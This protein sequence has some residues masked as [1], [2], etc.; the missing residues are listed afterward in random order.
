ML[1]S[2]VAAGKMQPRIIGT[3]RARQLISE[4]QI[5]AG[6]GFVDAPQ[7]FIPVFE[8]RGKLDERH[9]AAE[10][11]VQLA[12]EIHAL[13]GPFEFLIPGSFELIKQQGGAA[14]DADGAIIQNSGGERHSLVIEENVNVMARQAQ[15]DDGKKHWNDWIESETTGPISIRFH[16]KLSE[17]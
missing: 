6:H 7:S 8:D 15:K 13:T 17:Y 3:C 14:E 10:A 12:D 16:E 2:L 5:N 9:S 1:E 4:N 11:A